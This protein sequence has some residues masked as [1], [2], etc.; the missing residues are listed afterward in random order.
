MNTLNLQSPNYW[1]GYCRVQQDRRT[2]PVGKNTGSQL[3]KWWVLV[4]LLFI[5]F[6][7]SDTSPK[8]LSHQRA[9]FWP[10]L[11]RLAWVL[12]TIPIHQFDFALQNHAWTFLV[13]F[14]IRYIFSK[15]INL[16]YTIVDYKFAVRQIMN[17]EL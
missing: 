16:S 12:C 6:L 15:I 10:Y 9:D 14:T 5:W 7:K 3:S 11:S 4:H 1:H 13:K 8:R 17:R 2:N